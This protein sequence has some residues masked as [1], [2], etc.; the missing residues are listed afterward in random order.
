MVRVFPFLFLQAFEESGSRTY[1]FL[2]LINF[3]LLHSLTLST[4]FGGMSLG[5]LQLRFQGGFS[6][7][8]TGAIIGGVSRQTSISAVVG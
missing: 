8:S 3:N 6:R 1:F 2:C 4:V 7:M 5:E